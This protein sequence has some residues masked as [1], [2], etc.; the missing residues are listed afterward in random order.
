[1]DVFQKSY[2]SQFYSLSSL[3]IIYWVYLRNIDNVNKS[4]SREKFSVSQLWAAN[5]ENPFQS[6]GGKCL[7][8]CPLSSIG[9]NLRVTILNNFE[10]FP[11]PF[12]SYLEFEWA[13]GGKNNLASM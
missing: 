1:M 10:Q 13:F 4:L 8:C 12:S 11:F 2:D 9:R 7:H 5:L 6:G 3:V